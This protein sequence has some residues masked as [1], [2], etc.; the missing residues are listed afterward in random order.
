[1]FHYLSEYFK[2]VQIHIE[3]MEDIGIGNSTITN[4]FKLLPVVENLSIDPWTVTVIHLH[5]I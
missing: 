2:L 5:G 4:F 1:M 3:W